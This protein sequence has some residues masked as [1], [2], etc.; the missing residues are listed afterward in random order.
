MAL[1]VTDHDLSSGATTSTEVATPNNWRVT[2]T[3]TGSNFLQFVT[4]YLE[5]EDTPGNW[6]P[7]KD[8]LGKTIQMMLRGNETKSINALVVNGAN[9]RVQVVPNTD[10]DGTINVDSINA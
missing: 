9:G 3:V 5:V 8:N 10:H 2:A 1:I 7:L 6:S 4:C